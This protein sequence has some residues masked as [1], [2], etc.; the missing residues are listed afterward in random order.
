MLRILTIMVGALLL[1]ASLTNP[2][3][4]YDLNWSLDRRVSELEKRVA[5]LEAKVN[6]K[7]TTAPAVTNTLPAPNVGQPVQTFYNSRGVAYMQAPNG[8]M[9]LCPNCPRA[10]FG[11]ACFGGNCGTATTYYGAPMTI[12]SDDGGGFSAGGETTVIVNERPRFQPIRNAIRRRGAGGGC[13][14]GG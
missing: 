2:A 10:T 9:V 13:C 7:A 4:A 5:D 1:A 14:G 6:A 8:E 11:G 12:F 3:K